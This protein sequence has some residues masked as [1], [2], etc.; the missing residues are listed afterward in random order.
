MT[1][2]NDH[3]AISVF[4]FWLPTFLNK[5]FQSLYFNVTSTVNGVDDEEREAF[6]ILTSCSAL[7]RKVL[8]PTVN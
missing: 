1:V 2:S 8:V 6:L 7:I 4:V 5:Y 3:M